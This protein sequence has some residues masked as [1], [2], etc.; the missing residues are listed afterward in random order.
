LKY[1]YQMPRKINYTYGFMMYL[2]NMYKRYSNIK[3]ERLIF[4]FTYTKYIEKEMLA[5]L[6]IIFT[7]LKSG[8]NEIFLRGL[9]EEQRTMLVEFKFINKDIDIEHENSYISYNIFDADDR[10]AFRKYL[11]DEI[12]DIGSDVISRYIITHIMEIFLNIR[13]HARKNIDKSKFGNKE[14]FASGYFDKQKRELVLAICNNGKTFA[15]NIIEKTKIDYLEEFNYIRWALEDYNSTTS[16]R[17]GG[18]GLSMVEELIIKCKGSLMICSGFGYY[19][20]YFD[21]ECI[22][23]KEMRDLKLEF[24]VTAVIIKIPI[25]NIQEV[26]VEVGEEF[27]ID[28]LI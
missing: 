26:L 7:K 15:K 21:K 2:S 18:A 8:K 10:D 25:G 12:K 16:G 14:V 27:S 1:I 11:C 24:P 4:D 22:E 5:V 13:P 23:I 28:D 9:S 6:G 3:E 20:K 17:P 19:L